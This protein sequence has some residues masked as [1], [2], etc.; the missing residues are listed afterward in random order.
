M[1]TANSNIVAARL[2][3]SP[4]PSALSAAPVATRSAF[5]EA[6][7]TVVAHSTAAVAS[8]SAAPPA[9]VLAANQPDAAVCDFLEN[10]VTTELAAATSVPAAAT[11][12]A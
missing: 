12:V 11:T 1:P 2:S 3:Q 5:N 6:L 8:A 9:A 10:H 4:P 7:P